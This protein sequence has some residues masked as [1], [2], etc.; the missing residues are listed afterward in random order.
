MD[1]SGKNR[2]IEGKYHGKHYPHLEARV[3]A[4]NLKELTIGIS[5][6]EDEVKDHKYDSKRKSLDIWYEPYMGAVAGLHYERFDVPKDIKEIN[7]YDIGQKV[8]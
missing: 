2:K 8:K 6:L 5:L 1:L 4:D 7:V 3:F